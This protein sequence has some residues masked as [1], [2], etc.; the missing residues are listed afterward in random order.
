MKNILFFISLLLTYMGGAQNVG[1][2]T[3]SPGAKLEVLG[4][5]MTSD[6]MMTN[7]AFIN[8]LLQSDGSGNASWVDPTSVTTSTDLD[9]GINGNEIYNLNSGNVGVGTTNPKAL[10]NVLSTS[11]TNIA[12]VLVNADTF[13]MGTSVAGYGF[14]LHP[15]NKAKAAIYFKSP[16]VGVGNQ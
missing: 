3:T 14:S 6:F 11:N 5:T 10:F 7:G 15:T 13:V 9:W 1:I 16:Q 4:K 8:Y 2:G 12:S